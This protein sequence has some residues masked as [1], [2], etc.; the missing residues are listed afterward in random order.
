MYDRDERKEQNLLVSIIGFI[1]GFLIGFFSIKT[2][3]R[4]K[5]L[6]LK[7]LMNPKGE[8]KSILIV[9]GVFVGLWFLVCCV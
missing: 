6:T 8:L 1:I 9:I 2:I 5:G 4:L 7:W 3:Q